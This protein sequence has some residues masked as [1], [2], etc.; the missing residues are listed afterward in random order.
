MLKSKTARRWCSIVLSVCMLLSLLLPW[1]M[2]KAEAA[3]G[4]CGSGD[5]E[6]RFGSTQVLI[7]NCSHSPENA[8]ANFIG[9]TDGYSYSGI[10]GNHDFVNGDLFVHE[11]DTMNFTIN[12]AQNPQLKALAQGGD[13]TVAIGWSY[14]E[15]VEEHCGFLGIPKCWQGT[16]V[17][18]YVDGQQVVYDLA[19]H[20][21]AG[22]SKSGDIH[23][24]E[25]SVINVVVKG[26]RDETD[27]PSG[28]R[29]LYIRFKDVKRPVLTGYTF[30]G[31]GAFRENKKI[32]PAQT[33]LY[34]K[35]N[36]YFSLAYN[37]SEPV[38]PITLSS[39]YNDPFLRHP[40][41]V[42]PAG[43]GLPAAG[44]QQYLK[45]VNYSAADFAKGA[46]SV[47][48]NKS[49]EYKYTASKYHHSGNLPL[50]PKLE[51][52]SG[53][54]GSVFD[55]D[56]SLE[57]KFRGAVLADAAGNIVLDYS[58]FNQSG[59]D[60]SAA[61]G[62]LQGK[63]V[64][65]F[66]YNHQGLRVI[67]DAVPPKY[68]KVGNGIQPEILTGVTLNKNDAFDFTVQLTEEAQ[69]KKGWDVND[70]YLLLN[71]GMKA[72]YVKGDNS[73]KWT[74]HL[75]IP[76]GVTVE[77]PLLKA[78]A[79]TNKANVIDPLTGEN[80]DTGVLQDY[81]GNLLIQPANYEG[82][83]TDPEDGEDAANV[84]S[85][86][87]W[88]QLSIDNTQ[89]EISYRYES[90]GAT[91]QVY[92]KN[93][94]VT[95]DANDPALIVPSLDPKGPGEVRPSRGIYRPSNMTG[96][97]SPAVGLVYYMWSQSAT[98]PFANKAGDHFAAL[99]R[100]SLSAKQP[101]E[102]LYPGSNI[103]L[104]VAN[105]KT[106][107]IAL[108]AEALTE[109]KSGE[110]YLHTW[111][112]DMTWDSA[113]ELMQY[114]KK[115]SYI[116][117][118][119][120][121]YNGWIAEAPGS[122]ADKIF[123]ADN[124][125]L[126]KVG[127]YGDLAVWPLT[128]FEKEDSN[129][130]HSVGTIK[131]D[132]KA[133]AVAYVEI[134]GDNTPAVQVKVR[135]TDEHSGV[136]GSSYQWVKDG[137]QP[138]DAA[139]MPVE[140]A[141][142]SATLTTQ[143]EVVEDGAYWL[144]VRTVDNAGNERTVHNDKTVTVNSSG[145]ISGSYL[146]EA[147]PS[148]VQS[149]DV[150]FKLTGLGSISPLTLSTVTASAYGNTVAQ[151]TYGTVTQSAYDASLLSLGDPLYATF[152]G[153][154]Y[155]S[156]P[157]R[158]EESS[159]TAFSS[160]ANG[161]NGDRIYTVP[162]DPGK[163]GSQYVHILA[164][165]NESGFE[166]KYFFAK[167]YKFDNVAPVVT[168]SK[169]GVA[170]PQ[171]SQNVTVTVPVNPDIEAPIELIKY[172]WIDEQLPAPAENAPGWIDLP[173]DGKA[174]IT[175]EALKPGE[176]KN[177]RLYVWAKDGAKNGVIAQTTGVFAVS[178]S[179]NANTPPADV[180]SDLIYLYGDEEDGYTAIVQLGLDTGTVDKGGYDF[181]V[182]PDNGASWVKWRPYTN[183][184]ALKVPTNNTNDLHI[185]VKY[186][187]SAG[188]VGQPKNL[189]AS[190]MP[191]TMPVYA[192]ASLSSDR[193]A[194]L[195]TGVDIDIAA[196][197]GI[198]V[199][200]AAANPSTPVRSGNT[201]HV[202]ANGLYTF[203]LTDNADASRKSTLYAVVKNIDT[204]PPT[205][206][207]EYLNTGKT[208]GNVTVQL[209]DLS[210]QVRITNPPGRSTYTFTENG[211]FEFEFVD[212]AGN[213]GKAK[214]AVDYIDKEAP[215][216]KIERSYAYGDNGSKTFGTITDDNGNVLFSNGVTLTVVK[217]NPKD[218]DFIVPGGK[219]TAMLLQNGTASFTVSDVYGNTTVV[220]ETVDNII[221]APPEADSI[222]YTFVDDAGNALPEDR[223]V[224]VN[225][226]PYA[227]GKMK[228]TLSGNVTAPN[229][230]FAG[231]APAKDADG[232]YTNRISGDD[233]SFTY[234]RT[235]S[236]D[237]STLVALTDLLGNTKKV[238]VTIQGLDNTAPSI[239]LKMSSV[240]VT[241]NKPDF[242]FLTD[243]GGYA[244]SD[245]V[246]SADQI[247]VAIS[248]LDLGKL[249][250]Q[251]VTYTAT[252]QVGNTAVAYQDVTVVSGDGMLIFADGV[253]LSGSSVE[254]AL[255]D[256]NTLTFSIE[257]FNV[258]NVDGQKQVNEWGT[259]DLFYQPGLY[260]EGQ[261]K[262][263]ASQVSYGDLVKGQYK[264][265]FPEAGWYTII[266]RNQ[267]RER[268][269]ATFFIGK[270]Q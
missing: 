83:F 176:Q 248:G 99:K 183:F 24:T 255:F 115:Q 122:E 50:E 145:R 51:K 240:G 199:V 74:F 109:E 194:S 29:G 112:S 267:E 79:L 140:L 246:S 224:T 266:V 269:Y 244:V 170:Y 136:A 163:N 155:S 187:T 13:A 180:Q 181:S 226:V 189:D 251:R 200:P 77:A 68:T 92:Q 235:F 82:I 55:I 218:K 257:K 28:P 94:K 144:Y 256:T 239:E 215:K 80:K 154:A 137:S 17:W 32:E 158:P 238:P 9:K 268:E 265:T 31:N 128:D 132:N 186:R 169:S 196:P 53:E 21:G 86:I 152:A 164:K 230:V 3:G 100:F 191:K 237:G 141:G 138:Q 264:V 166:K 56:S 207:V 213:T 171:D 116:Q 95:I 70:T 37:F 261:M 127:S 114:T 133:P 15:W 201:F 185:Q 61:G 84:N 62:Y 130:V 5:Q 1:D 250:R 247:R 139:W 38:R 6:V 97:S 22:S 175:N 88:A 208:N 75:A 157:V 270:K 2:P 263:I 161:D 20:G 231:T 64:N 210:E 242:N 243:L 182:S 27:A 177:F 124:K 165:I 188:V 90:G 126:E 60:S 153:Y 47:P 184:V 41:F 193:P 214:A 172:Q 121:E 43:T 81:A 34:A 167:E 168:F 222:K 162:A 8:L 78:I 54:S 150:Q 59:D 105:N 216:V 195:E 117:Q 219:N 148:F 25:N 26:V 241:Q 209:T 7:G 225:G 202:N 258:M 36:E 63:N 197:L 142:D 227:K 35:K 249:G 146:T 245:N 259:Y 96:S 30:K 14:L 143:N 160:Y 203:E 16:E 223:I 204:T 52:A 178:K 173:E 67:V 149:H 254:S 46:L 87:D 33:E 125:A 106:N 49:L 179:E 19:Y 71:N 18:G 104:S 65:P 58:K 198:K 212:E 39:A 76:D 192:L 221:S 4:E 205:G 147:S 119:P 234:S 108:P 129:W 174:V 217:Q 48:L 40:L 107:L 44:E 12:V 159:F 260:R 233:G 156:S 134:A 111:T 236:A 98:D 123:Y 89:P 232:K 120:E 211:S 85:K 135:I 72:T 91:D 113:R 69:V 206:S 131:L 42:N 190:N 93:G 101:G 103:Q 220:K 102:D 253:L 66:D 229:M 151:T 228:V 262:Y 10:G 110:W 118:H 73:D 57:Q 11:G 252:D 23:I 45:S